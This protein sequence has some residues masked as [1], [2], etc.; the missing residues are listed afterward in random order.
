[1]LSPLI[2]TGDYQ[3]RNAINEHASP[4]GSRSF[5]INGI[6]TDSWQ[7]TSINVIKFLYILLNTWKVFPFLTL[8]AY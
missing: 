4:C 5:F 6:W 8:R 7:Y 2:L 3:M 1:M